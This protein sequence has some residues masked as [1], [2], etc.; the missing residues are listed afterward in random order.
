MFDAVLP[1]F[2]KNEQ[3]LR[4]I[5]SDPLT[6][7]TFLERIADAG[8][9]TEKLSTLQ[10]M[11]AAEKS[12]LFDVLAYFSFSL[13]PITRAER[14]A[15]AMPGIFSELSDKQ[16]EFLDYI[17]SNYIENGNSILEEAKLADLVTL[18]YGSFSDG[19]R[20]F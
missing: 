6:R 12:D 19:E 13:P 1:E 16:E 14:V 17:L 10:K 18:K 5:W 7:K 9:D 8:C 20:A 11:I 2:F 3:E 15:E 4:D